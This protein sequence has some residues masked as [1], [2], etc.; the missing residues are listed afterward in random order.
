MRNT[1]FHD[2]TLKSLGEIGDGPSPDPQADIPWLQHTREEA[3]MMGTEELLENYLRFD[4]DEDT[5][6]KAVTAD[7]V[8][9]QVGMHLSDKTEEEWAEHMGVRVP[10]V[11]NDE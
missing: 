10:E 11:G 6:I 5:Q 3:G 7:A 9:R 1:V 4:W 8:A 2:D